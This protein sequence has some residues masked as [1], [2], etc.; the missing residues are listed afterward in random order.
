MKTTGTWLAALIFC[1]TILHVKAQNCVPVPPPNDATVSCAQ[2][3]ATLHT[4]AG[5][6]YGVGNTTAYQTTDIP[7][8]PCPLSG[9]PVLI[10]IDD[11]WSNVLNLPFTF[12]FYGQPYTQCLIGSNGLLSFDL[13]N[14]GGGCQWVINN[15]I[16]SAN[17]P[18]NCIM[19]P[20]QDIDPGV[21]GDIYYQVLGTAPQRVFVVSFVNVAMFQCN[22]LIHTSQIKIYETT[23]V[24]DI[25]IQNKPTC[26]GWNGGAA[27]EGIQNATG[28]QAVWVNGR[29]YPTQWTATNDTKRFLPIG[30]P[31][32][33]SIAWFHNGT[34][35]GTGDSVQVCPTSIPDMYVAHITFNN[36]ATTTTFYDTVN[37]TSSAAVLGLN[38]NDTTVNNCPGQNNLGA[39]TVNVPGGNNFSYNWSTGDTTPIISNLAAGTYYVTVSDTTGCTGSDSATVTINNINPLFDAPSVQNPLCFGGST[40]RASVSINGGLPGF[41]FTWSNGTVNDTAYNLPAGNYTVT[42]NNGTGCTVS[43]SVQLTDPLPLIID[44]ANVVDVGCTGNVFGSIT[45]YASGGTGALNY[46]WTQV[47]GGASLSGQTINNLAVGSYTL[48]VSDANSCTANSSYQV[49]QVAQL[50]FVSQAQS[51]VSCY[52]GGDGMASIIVSGGLP[53][54]TYNW[55]N[56]GVIPDSVVNNIPAGNYSVTVSDVNSCTQTASYTITQPASIVVPWQVTDVNCFGGADGTITANPTGGTPGNPVAYN[57]TWSNNGQATQTATGLTA[58]NYTVT[59]T[60]GNGCTASQQITVNQPTQLT[61]TISKTDA[62]CFGGNQGT[63]TVIANGGTVNY[64]YQWSDGQNT[65]TA[66][67]LSQGFYSNTVTDANGC[68]VVVSTIIN[69]PTQLMIDTVTTPVTCA[70]YSDGTATV[71]AFN[72][73]PPYTF[74]I[75]PDNVNFAFDSSGY[76]TGLS[77]GTYTAIVADANSCTRTLAFM[78]SNPVPD[79]YTYVIDSTSCYG[80]DYND[81]AIHLSATPLYNGPFTYDID[82]GATQDSPDFLNL[83]AGIHEVTGYNVNGCVTDLQIIVPEPMPVMVQIIPDTVQLPLGNSIQI[84]TVVQNAFNQTYLWQPSAGLSCMDCHNPIGMPYETT[85]YNLTVSFVNNYL[86]RN[87][88]CY[89]YDDLY[90]EVLPHANVYVPNAFTPNG[91]GTNDLFTVYGQDIREIDMKVF[92]RWGEKVFQT[93]STNNGWDGTYKGEN[94][95]QGIYTYV[96]QITFLDSKKQMENG[97]IMLVR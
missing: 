51:E 81:G 89:G 2:P 32:S 80:N 75:T 82:N 47:N 20:F 55:S 58:N 34:Q 96:V 1:I 41:T 61:A 28:T 95:P 26:A 25:L 71:T 21:A 37:V 27:I 35:I 17:N 77:A 65:P 4:N 33:L 66:V 79:A 43:T 93:N 73:T 23:N 30:A 22:A 86:N 54:Y 91:D 85:S 62:L 5:A 59:V 60:D 11:T 18:T 94:V 67:M 13:S 70:G 14:A 69:E 90:I 3:C 48:T 9:T 63:A 49:N 92:N 24:I 76:F 19:G 39:L 12:Y 64:L 83:S 87:V 31:N 57:Y 42:A 68:S 46:N 53:P 88:T 6:F 10:N 50:N 78:I 36:G 72:A 7:Y 52:N 74:S 38:L 84:N 56:A 8:N 44:S 40:G 45:A 97:S 16:P 15:A 29:N